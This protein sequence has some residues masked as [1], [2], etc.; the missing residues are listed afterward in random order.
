MIFVTA[1]THFGHTNI[2]KYT[3]RPFT[4]VEE[5][6]AALIANWNATVGNNDVVYHLGD[7][8]L[9]NFD[10]FVAYMGALQGQIYIVP[11]SHDNN[12]LEGWQKQMGMRKQAVY[13]ASGLQVLLR[14]PLVTLR[15][16]IY[17]GS[18]AGIPDPPPAIVLCHY[19]MLSWEI[20]HYGS[21]QLYGHH[22][23]AL[24]TESR[25]SIDVGVDVWG[26]KPVT[27]A[28]IGAV[29]AQRT[30]TVYKYKQE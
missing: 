20:S 28:E 4:T 16:N 8:A 29:F 2:I 3:N 22:H 9:R 1:D 21:W 15:P 10:A 6:D 12:W 25:Y 7:V 26:Y 27:L 14:P 24:N 23:G 17:A 5:M 13:S 18:M 11:G 19:A 30:V